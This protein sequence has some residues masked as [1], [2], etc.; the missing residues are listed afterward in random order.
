ER[1]STEERINGVQ[2]ALLKWQ[3]G[4]PSPAEIFDGIRAK[5]I[6]RNIQEF[7]YKALHK[8]QKIG[9][10]WN[11]IPNYEHQTLCSGCEQTET[12]E[13]KLLEFPYNEQET[14]W[15]MTR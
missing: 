1:K 8:T 7:M 9:T 12:L 4:Q 5:V 14:V 15:D 6:S 3:P 11:H 13:H 10:Y 2:E